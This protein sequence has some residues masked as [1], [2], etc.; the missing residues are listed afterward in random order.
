MIIEVSM[1]KG[2]G[3]GIFR[4]GLSISA[5]LR[6]C[7]IPA[8]ILVLFMGLA[9]CGPSKSELSITPPATPPLSRSV[10][11]YGVITMSYTRV[12]DE[13]SQAGVSLGYLRKNSIVRVLER[14]TIKDGNLSETWVLTEGTYRGWL[15]EA[16]VDVYDNEAKAQTAV[17]S[18]TE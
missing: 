1:A 10:L 14:R 15:P 4:S 3:V 8:A 7:H 6:H 18:V 12:M 2:Q 16:V 13:P 9:A 11:G 5:F 17:E